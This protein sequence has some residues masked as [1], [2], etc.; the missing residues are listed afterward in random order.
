VRIHAAFLL[1]PHL[2]LASACSTLGGPSRAGAPGEPDASRVTVALDMGRDH[3]CR[4][5]G[6]GQLW[7]WGAN[8]W[9]QVR[10]D[11]RTWAEP[12]QRAYP[13]L[14][15]VAQVALSPSHACVLHRTGQVSCWGANQNGQL[16][17]GSNTSRHAP[18]RVAGLANVDA[19]MVAEGLSCAR[20][21]ENGWHCWGGESDEASSWYS[22]SLFRV[23]PRGLPTP[24]RPSQVSALSLRGYTGAA[25]SES[26]QVLSWGF[27]DWNGESDRASFEV[28]GVSDA[29]AVQ[30]GYMDAC[31]LRKNGTIA[32]WATNAESINVVTVPGVEQVRSLSTDLSS[33][34]AVRH[35]DSLWCFTVD[36][37]DSARTMIEHVPHWLEK[38]ESNA[39]V[40]AIAGGAYLGCVATSAGTLRC[41]GRNHRG[42]L[43]SGRTL[44]RTTPSEVP[45][46]IDVTAI[47]SQDSTTCAL[48]ADGKVWCWGGEQEPYDAEQPTVQRSLPTMVDGVSDAVEL[49]VPCARRR[50]DSI[51]CWDATRW[52][53]VVSGTVTPSPLVT[54]SGL[55]ARLGAF[56]VEAQAAFAATLDG[57]LSYFGAPMGKAQPFETP[58]FVVEVAMGI[59]HRCARTRSGGVFCW[60]SNQ[61]GQFGDGTRRAGPEKNIK[62]VV[63]QTLVPVPVLGIADATALWADHHQTCLLRRDD[64]APWCFGNLAHDGPIGPNASLTPVRVTS[65]A[66]SDRLALGLAHLCGIDAQGAVHCEGKSAGALLGTNELGVTRHTPIRD[67]VT[68][69][70][71]SA[72]HTCALRRGR[73]LCWGAN[74]TGE[75]G[76]GQLLR[77]DQEAT[78][79]FTETPTA[80]PLRRIE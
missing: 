16:G 54:V 22:R 65:L 77:A 1:A 31:A 7:C 61:Y 45:G 44:E 75:L 20:Q 39:R 66:G 57:R 30:A 64:P 71:A 32:C 41:R 25:V 42:A 26:G 55:P 18:T 11:A 63:D 9:G 14:D 52:G 51:V 48:R 24:A 46:L 70:S 33:Y 8:D 23:V 80:H 36:A 56:D 27:G 6:S 29:R 50:D 74:D 72:A 21:R 5:D 17:D 28:P 19:I 79:R 60:G 34:C 12:E 3:A 62:G 73:V 37:Q 38:A 40:T 68:M 53:R 15:A 43:G 59:Q 78:V 69:L 10:P 76:N 67:G 35:D 47:D 2:L 49:R 13:G 58:G 4:I